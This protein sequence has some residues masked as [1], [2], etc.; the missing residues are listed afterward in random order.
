MCAADLCPTVAAGTSE[1]LYSSLNLDW[2]DIQTVSLYTCCSV[3]REQATAVHW[4]TSSALRAES[5]FLPPGTQLEC[6]CYQAWTWRTAPHAAH[7]LWTAGI[8]PLTAFIQQVISISGH[9]FYSNKTIIRRVVIISCYLWLYF[10]ACMEKK[11]PVS[12]FF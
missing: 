7:S 3:L 1:R 11:D 4:M 12:S 9:L 2:T 5:W 8:Q 6:C 10:M